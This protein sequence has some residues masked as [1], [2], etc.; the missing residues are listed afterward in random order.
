MFFASWLSFLKTI[1]SPIEKIQII[2][3]RAVQTALNLTYVVLSGKVPSVDSVCLC[4]FPDNA[5]TDSVPE[6]AHLFTDSIF[7]QS[8]L[9]QQQNFLPIKKY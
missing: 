8:V 4:V 1:C 6:I 9:Q 7:S 3:V 5:R 2:K